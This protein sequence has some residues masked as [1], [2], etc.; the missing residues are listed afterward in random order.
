M[1]RWEKGECVKRERKRKP[2]T[3]PGGSPIQEKEQ[4]QVK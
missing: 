3:E 1:E 4:R 2:K